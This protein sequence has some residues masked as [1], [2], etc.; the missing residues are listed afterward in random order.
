M[1]DA[2][3]RPVAVIDERLQFFHQ[4]LTVGVGLSAT[5]PFVL[6]VGVFVDATFPRVVD[7]DDDQRLDCASHS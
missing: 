4:H 1:L 2:G 3:K 7:A 6:D 5:E